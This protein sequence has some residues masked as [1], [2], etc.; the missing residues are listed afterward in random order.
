VKK[1]I[2]ATL[3]AGM[4]AVYSLAMRHHSLETIKQFSTSMPAGRS[5][6]TSTGSPAA[7]SGGAGATTP[8]SDTSTSY[9]DGSY[10]GSVEDAYYGSV[11]VA[12]TV[13]GGK[14]TKVSFLQSPHTRSTSV[15]INRFAIPGLQQEAISAQSSDV[16]AISGATF[17]SQAFVQ[18]LRT[19]LNQAKRS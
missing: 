13:A 14:I 8:T 4:F 5:G 19:A 7:A 16:Q 1:L 2:V 17:T 11:Q 10:T 6:G 9:K 12:V 18:S 15:M 3:T